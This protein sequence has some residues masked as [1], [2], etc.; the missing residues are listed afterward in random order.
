MGFFSDIVSTVTAPIVKPIQSITSHIPGL[1]KIP[2]FNK[3]TDLVQLL[4][5]GGEALSGLLEKLGVGSDITGFLKDPA[6]AFDDLLGSLESRSKDFLGTDVAP[7]NVDETFADLGAGVAASEAFQQSPEQQ[8]LIQALM[9]QAQ[10]QG[11]SL[12]DMQSKQTSNRLLNDALSAQLSQRGVGA[13]LAARNVQQAKES[14]SRELP[15]QMAMAR[16]QEQRQGQEAAGQMLEADRQAAISGQQLGLDERR[17]R[18]E[19]QMGKAKMELEAEQAA[20]KR[21]ADII[22]AS[23]QATASILKPIV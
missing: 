22:A 16:L 15:L 10:G 3:N 20:R 11:P 21:R 2:G 17:A 4:T 14:A 1:N 7:V 6:S 18:S 23:G 12:A 13:G 5:G 19:E 9:A 8:Q